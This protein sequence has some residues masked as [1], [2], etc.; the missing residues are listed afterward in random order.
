MCMLRSDTQEFGVVT[1]HA[2]SLALYDQ[3]ATWVFLQRSLHQAFVFH[4]DMMPEL[5]VGTNG[6]PPVDANLGEIMEL[7]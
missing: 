5:R 4:R 3:W 1:G 7:I 2:P 6:M